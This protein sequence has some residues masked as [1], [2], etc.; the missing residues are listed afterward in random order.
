MVLMN[1]LPR[2]DHLDIDHCVFKVH[3]DFPISACQRHGYIVLTPE[4]VWETAESLSPQVRSV[5]TRASPF[6]GGLDDR[7]SRPDLRTC[8]VTFAK[9]YEQMYAAH[10]GQT[11]VS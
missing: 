5:C 4:Q 11:P 1:I 2:Y 3:S 8:L 10:I 6:K 7:H 9:T